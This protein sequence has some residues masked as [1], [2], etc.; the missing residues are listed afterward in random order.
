MNLIKHWINQL[1][2][3]YGRTT[4]SAFVFTNWDGSQENLDC[5]SC[6]SCNQHWFVSRALDHPPLHCPF[7]RESFNG[8][9]PIKTPESTKI[10][11]PEGWY[12]VGKVPLKE[13]GEGKQVARLPWQDP[14]NKEKFSVNLQH[15]GFMAI[16]LETNGDKEIHGA[17][18]NVED[19]L[20]E[21]WIVKK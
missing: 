17:F 12:F 4:K 6:Q 10:T 11:V 15:S 20:A 7:C 13:I 8:V 14:N 1:I 9:L 16:E 5:V 2:L 18:S 21:D 19:Y 3:F